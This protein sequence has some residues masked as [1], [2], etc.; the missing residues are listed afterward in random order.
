MIKN[1][2]GGAYI[3][4]SGSSSSMPY[5]SPGANGAGMVRYNGNSQ[6]MEV[7]DGNSWL[8][9][10]MSYPTIELSRDAVEV[11]EWARLERTKQRLLEERI[12]QNPSLKKAYESV[13]RAKENFDILD[14]I[15]GETDNNDMGEVQAG[16]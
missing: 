13:L 2:S 16:P 10:N 8:S 15:V 12:E 4:V 11:L 3:T 5:I 14:K 6:Q 1:I 7:N 9:I